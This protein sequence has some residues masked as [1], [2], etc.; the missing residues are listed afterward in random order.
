MLNIRRARRDSATPQPTNKLVRA[1]GLMHAGSIRKVHG[2]MPS[3]T[4]A[5]WA[6]LPLCWRYVTASARKILRPLDPV[7]EFLTFLWR[8]LLFHSFAKVTAQLYGLDQIPS[9]F[10]AA[11]RKDSSWAVINLYHRYRHQHGLRV[12]KTEGGP[13]SPRYCVLSDTP[14]PE[15]CRT[16]C[17]LLRVLT[18]FLRSALPGRFSAHAKLV[19]LGTH[20]LSKLCAEIFA[21]TARRL[22]SSATS[23]MLALPSTL[24]SSIH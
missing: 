24:G 11:T 9:D 15:S 17:H 14:D 18:F 8:L 23:S 12:G 10:C 4:C 1:H 22:P 7:A 13:R 6:C 5:A 20:L 2:M 19:V 16:Y 3:I 21:G